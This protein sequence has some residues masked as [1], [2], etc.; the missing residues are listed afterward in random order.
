MPEQ[1]GE[2][3]QE[4]TQHRRQQA[5]E[6]G[7]VARS[8]DF[9]SALL[10]V[11]GTATLMLMGGS[12]VGAFGMLAERQLGGPAWLSSDPAFLLQQC[13]LIVDQMA[14]VLLPIFALL[15]LYGIAVNV[16]QVGFLF[17][18]DKL[19]AD[20]SRIHP[21]QG[22]RR[23]FSLTSVMRLAF[24]MLKVLVVAAVAAVSLY[25]HWEQILTLTALSIPEIAAFLGD[26]IVWT[27]LQIGLALL[28]LALLDYAYQRWKQEQD[29]RMTHQ[30]VREE[31][32]N[33]QG[34]PQVIARRRAVQRQLALNRLSSTVPQADVVVTN[35]TEL[36]IAI[37]Y[38]PGT[39]AAPI[40]SAK[41]AGLIAQRIRRIALEHDIPIVEN[42]PLAR[43][44]YR[45]VDENRPIPDDLYGAVA[46]LLAY[47]YKLKGKKVPAAPHQR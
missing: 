20:F 19:A 43:R 25:R 18:P 46:E 1:N 24:G 11:A 36:A 27:I 17:L 35:P 12:V 34:D 3:N 16:M 38:D 13:R 5:R 32:K 7:Q 30:E 42:K 14:E 21:L 31:M 8:Q 47:V 45:E 23:L 40:V 9:S 2:K 4:P 44:L 29:L 26:L 28:L 22:A 10:L 6:K 39:M 37:R 33:L 15:M 41:G